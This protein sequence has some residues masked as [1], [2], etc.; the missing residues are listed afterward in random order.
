L[1]LEYILKYMWLC[2]HFNVCFSL[3]FSFADDLLLAVNFIFILD[4]RN[5]V[6]QKADLSDFFFNLS[7]EWAVKH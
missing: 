3:F 5:D 4:Y 1:I 6:K 7:S 2:Y